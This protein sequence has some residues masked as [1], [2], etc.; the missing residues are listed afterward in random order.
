MTGYCLLWC[1]NE[2]SYSA[3]SKSKKIMA[4]SM[5]PAFGSAEFRPGRHPHVQHAQPKPGSGL[6]C[7]RFKPVP[8]LRFPIFRVGFHQF[9]THQDL[10]PLDTF[11]QGTRW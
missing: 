1:F 10:Y 4:S 7:K 3:G 5:R 11:I 2:Q 8:G 6:H 9:E